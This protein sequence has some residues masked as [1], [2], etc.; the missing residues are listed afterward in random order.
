MNVRQLI[1]KLNKLPADAEV[2]VEVSEPY[3]GDR[4]VRNVVDVGHFLGNDVTISICGAY[5]DD[6]DFEPTR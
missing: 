2:Y 1:E 4:V 6:C 3:E 5:Y